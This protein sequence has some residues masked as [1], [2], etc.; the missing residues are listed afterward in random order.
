MSG[1]TNQNSSTKK[2]I[3]TLAHRIE[4]SNVLKEGITRIRESSL[5]EAKEYMELYSAKGSEGVE[6]LG[7]E[8][9]DLGLRIHLDRIRTEATQQINALKQEHRDN[10]LKE[11]ITGEQQHTT[12]GVNLGNV[13]HSAET[14][15]ALG[16]VFVSGWA[17]RYAIEAASSANAA[18]LHQ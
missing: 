2:E 14:V 3:A 12:F 11:E 1:E 10:L 6:Q 8:L 16:S 18:S 7:P 9:K 13:F 4:R 5:K 15:L 17:L